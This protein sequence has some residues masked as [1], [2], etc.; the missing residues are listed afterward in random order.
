[1]IHTHAGLLA[2]GAVPV[3]SFNWERPDSYDV[4]VKQGSKQPVTDADLLVLRKAFGL[5]GL[6]ARQVLWDAADGLEPAVAKG[7]SFFFAQEVK[8][9]GNSHLERKPSGLMVLAGSR[10]ATKLLMR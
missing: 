6:K 2:Q 9:R 4:V 8:N 10:F 3:G 1:M 5:V 7:L